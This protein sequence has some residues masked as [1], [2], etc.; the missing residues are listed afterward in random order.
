MAEAPEETIARVWVEVKPLT[1]G[2]RAFR[3]YEDHAL[4]TF[5]RLED[6]SVEGEY[7]GVKVAVT[8]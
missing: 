8:G 4:M 1:R 2:A 5:T 3:T 6:G 7:K